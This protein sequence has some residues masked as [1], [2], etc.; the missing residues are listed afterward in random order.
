MKPLNLENL[1]INSL[2]ELYKN[3]GLTPQ[4]VINFLIARV[5]SLEPR[6]KAF[7]HF[8]KER[9]L[10]GLKENDASGGKALCGIPVTV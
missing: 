10:K 3:K 1:S 8:D 7:V 2:I 4:E 5:E 9:I 6:L